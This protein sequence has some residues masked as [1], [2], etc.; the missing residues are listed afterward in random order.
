MCPVQTPYGFR[1]HRNIKD[2]ADRRVLVVMWDV[3]RVALVYRRP[4]VEAQRI[5]LGK[6]ELRRILGRCRRNVLKD[7]L[8]PRFSQG[9]E[10]I[11]FATATIANLLEEAWLVILE[12]VALMSEEAVVHGLSVKK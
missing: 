11:D 6:H 2:A 7:I 12:G 9:E 1:R 10:G 3:R 4:H 8:K 5:W